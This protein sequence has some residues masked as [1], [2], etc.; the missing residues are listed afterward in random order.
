MNILKRNLQVLSFVS[1]SL[2]FLCSC[3]MEER[4]P[5]KRSKVTQ[6]K[7]KLSTS[8]EKKAIQKTKEVATH[9]NNTE[10]K[11]RLRPVVEMMTD[12]F[13]FNDGDGNVYQGTKKATGGKPYFKMYKLSGFI[14]YDQ[15]VTSSRSLGSGKYEV[16]VQAKL[17]AKN[18]KGTV[19]VTEWP[20]KFTWIDKEGEISLASVEYLEKMKWKS[21][22]PTKKQNPP[23]RVYATQKA[24]TKIEQEIDNSSS[25]ST[26]QKVKSHIKNQIDALN[27]KN[28]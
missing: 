21:K 14:A 1:V 4:R 25:A 7:K 20:V 3:E 27:K 11:V 17:E 16:E 28:R 23:A 15:K 18:P 2:L 8:S 22:N 10:A 13:E 26:N 19:K 5:R 6:K 24:A 12:D 9:I